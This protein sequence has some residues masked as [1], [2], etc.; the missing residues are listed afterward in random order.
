MIIGIDASNIRAGG[1]VTHLVHILPAG[2]PPR[3]D[4]Q[5]VYV[6]ANS[7]TARKLPDRS[8]LR[9][10]ADSRLDRS[11]PIR[12]FWQTFIIDR[13]ARQKGCNLLFVPGGSYRGTFRPVVT[14]S[15]NMLPFD[16]REMNRYRYSVMYWKFR[17][18]R[19]SQKRIF[20]NADGVIFLNEYARSHV[21]AQARL[22]GDWTI[23][24]HGVDHSF[25]SEP[26]PPRTLAEC[27]EQNPYRLLYV[28]TV[29][30]YK[31]QWHAAEAV[32][33]LKR[34]GLPVTLTLVGSAYPPALLRL[35]PT[36]E[37][38]DPHHCFIDYRG[39]IAHSQLPALYHQADAFIFASSCENM[40]NI[41]LEAMASGLPIAC[42]NRGP[43]P[44][45][46]GDAGV[47]FDPEKPGE[48]AAAIKA[49]ID[50]PE[51]AFNLAQ[52]AYARAREYSWEQCA[53]DTFSF[54][55]L[56]AKRKSAL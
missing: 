32:A 25:R 11:L 29:D 19:N 48:I 24:P 40:P 36:L 43:M 17:L 31:H 10:I 35:R 38:L 53:N 55:S 5:T 8:W 34:S 21:M 56:V 1:G 46:L 39:A 18:L 37:R 27:T 13:L 50:Q 51:K 22:K 3:H 45:V 15:R 54:L 42:S 20:R 9:V 41:L 28:S 26:H 7:D 16:E 52:R 6:W 12:Q 14:M 47:Y 33:G 23:I 30:L 44:E 49:L 2:D 4:I